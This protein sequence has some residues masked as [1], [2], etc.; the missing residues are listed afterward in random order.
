MQASVTP[1]MLHALGCGSAVG[2]APFI[3]SCAWFC[4]WAWVRRHDCDGYHKVQGAVL[5]ICN[6]LPSTV[7]KWVRWLNPSGSGGGQP[8]SR[9]GDFG[10]RQP[11]SEPKTWFG[12]RVG[13]LQNQ[14]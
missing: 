12:W 9:L 14:N 7:P 11:E 6:P 8:S 3:A 10:G 5:S 1:Q 2:N 13:A 4:W